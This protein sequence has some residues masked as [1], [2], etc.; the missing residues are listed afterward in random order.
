MKQFHLKARFSRRIPDPVFTGCTRYIFLCA[1]ED[2]PLEIPRDPNPRESDTDHG[3]YRE[4]RQ[5]LLNK[6]GEANT[7]HLKNKGITILADAVQQQDNNED[8]IVRL[9]D[10]QG[11]VDGGHTYKLLC[12]GQPEIT[13][14]N[15][16]G[17]DQITQFVKIEV[18]TGYSATIAL[19]VASGLNTAVQVQRMSL[20]N[21]KGNFQWIKDELCHESYLDKIAF[22]EREGKDRLL[23]VRDILVLLDL[24]NLAEFPT[25]FDS[26]QKTKYPI[27]AY[28]AKD[29]VLKSFEKTPKNYRQIRPI[30]KDI[31]TLH[32]I[33]SSEAAGRYTSESGG[34]GG[35]LKFVEYCDPKKKQKPFDFHFIG[36]SGNHR[37]FRSALF[38]MLGAFR[39]MTQLD[40]E[41][42][43]ISWKG[44]FNKVLEIWA[45]TSPALMEV[46]KKTTQEQGYNLNGVGKSENHWKSLYFEVLQAGMQA[47]L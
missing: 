46:T 25:K 11:I 41:T 9:A 44:G 13:R 38:P 21:L 14:I 10:G 27:R 28:S 36:K 20:D 40:V 24:F 18:L 35:R 16:S 5:H 12:Q 32:D 39:Y 19:E 4:I 15:G 47:G 26:K 2:V 3:I 8:F 30:L 31:L 22:R 29:A 42:E 7:F 6:Q 37:L 33:I 23:D 45:D 1:V 17:G 43:Q 34:R